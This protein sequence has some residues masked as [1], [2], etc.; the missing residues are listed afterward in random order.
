MEGDDGGTDKKST[1]AK[2]ILK[3]IFSRDFRLLLSSLVFELTHTIAVSKQNRFTLDQHSV[4]MAKHIIK[5][6]ILN[7]YSEVCL[8]IALDRIQT[9]NY[10]MV[11]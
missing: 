6:S 3:V 11:K 4:N 8:F 10:C 1:V 9:R 2:N 7:L 5:E